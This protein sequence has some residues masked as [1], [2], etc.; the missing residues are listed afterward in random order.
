[1][2]N[3]IGGSFHGKDA[4]VLEVYSGNMFIRSEN[5][6]WYRMTREEA[7]GFDALLNELDH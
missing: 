7:S 5:G 4:D 2:K 3:D 6:S 1:M